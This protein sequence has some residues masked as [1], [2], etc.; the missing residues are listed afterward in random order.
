MQ[1]PGPPDLQ[2]IQLV[3]QSVLVL[4]VAIGE[5]SPGWSTPG[6]GS[7]QRSCS[8][9]S[10]V[11]Y[12]IR[13]PIEDPLSAWKPPLLGPFRAWKPPILMVLYGIGELA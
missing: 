13:A 11:L 2:E 4:V 1:F 9:I 7:G 5:F 6:R 10:L 8:A 12:G 3:D